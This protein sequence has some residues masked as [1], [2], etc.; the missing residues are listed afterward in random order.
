MSPTIQTKFSPPLL[1][2][3]VTPL[4]LATAAWFV[5]LVAKFPPRSVGASLTAVTFVAVPLIEIVVVPVAIATLIRRPESR[6]A[7]NVSLTIFCSLVLL[8]AGASG[9]PH[10]QIMNSQ[11]PGAEPNK[12]LI[13]TRNGEAPLRAARRRR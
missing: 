2:G 11:P 10:L 9:H 12:P 5:Q 13:P 6:T 8:A 7:T 3:L 1:L 4:I